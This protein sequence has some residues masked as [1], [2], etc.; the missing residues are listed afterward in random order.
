MNLPFII[1]SIYITNIYITLHTEKR[2]VDST[3]AWFDFA[4]TYLN[5]LKQL[6][7]DLIQLRKKLTEIIYELFQ[8]IYELR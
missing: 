4:P 1:I 3:H 5:E 2:L 6:I 7:D 8:V